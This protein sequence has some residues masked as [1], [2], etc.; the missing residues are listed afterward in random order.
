MPSNPNIADLLA[1]PEG[2][3]LAFVRRAF[4]T[5]ELAETLAALAN[6]QG[7][8]VLV[9]VAPR[10]RKPEGLLDSEGARLAALDQQLAQRVGW[11]GLVSGAGAAQVLAVHAIHV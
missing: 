4:R 7:G 3:Q 6:A 2:P 5:D 10:S 11:D 1:Q 8:Q 9:G